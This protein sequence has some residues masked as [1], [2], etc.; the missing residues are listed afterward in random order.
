MVSMTTI[1][2]FL[3]LLNDPYQ[4]Q[5]FKLLNGHLIKSNDP[6]NKSS[7]PKKNLL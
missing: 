4:V 7:Y 5:G 1:Q 3:Y 2:L 6:F